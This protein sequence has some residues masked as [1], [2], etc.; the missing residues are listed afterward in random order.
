MCKCLQYGQKFVTKYYEF[1]SICEAAV[2]LIKLV[3]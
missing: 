3:P 1:C 2:E